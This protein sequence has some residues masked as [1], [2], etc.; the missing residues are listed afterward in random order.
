[1]G[2][3]HALNFSGPFR[4]SGIVAAHVEMVA[5]RKNAPEQQGHARKLW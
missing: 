4:L 3:Y 2:D 5:L 1:M